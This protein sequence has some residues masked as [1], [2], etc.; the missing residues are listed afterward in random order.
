MLQISV[1]SILSVLICYIVYLCFPIYFSKV[2]LALTKI[3]I[4]ILGICIGRFAIEKRSMS[5]CKYVT[6]FLCLI[7][8]FFILSRLDSF[9]MHYCDLSVFPITIWIVSLIYDMLQ[10]FSV[11]KAVTKVWSWMGK[12]T[13]E[14]YVLHLLLAKILNPVGNISMTLLVL[15]VP[16]ILCVPVQ[17]ITQKISG[18]WIRV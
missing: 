11:I 3:P 7:V 16:L 10:C 1:F 13:L 4:F 9:F 2:Y 8:L 18:L 6:L 15:I 14:L 17:K 5:S 12:Y